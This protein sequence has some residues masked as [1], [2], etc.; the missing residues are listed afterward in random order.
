MGFGR[1]VCHL[2]TDDICG[3]AA[4]TRRDYQTETR[5]ADGL[6]VQM[7]TVDKV[8]DEYPPHTGIY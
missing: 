5:F 8:I 3:E 6:P 7:R 2:P 4:A 1:P